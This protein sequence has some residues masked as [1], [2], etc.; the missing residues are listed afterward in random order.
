MLPDK[1]TFQRQLRRLDPDGWDTE[2]RFNSGSLLRVRTMVA[3]IRD[4]ILEAVLSQ[5]ENHMIDDIM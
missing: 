5:K 2:G 3:L 1:D 4:E